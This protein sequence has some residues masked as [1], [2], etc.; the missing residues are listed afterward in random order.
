MANNKSL[1]MT[2]QIS[3]Q[4]KV[5]KLV[6]LI[7]VVV[8][9]AVTA[10]AY[11]DKAS[12][13]QSAILR[14]QPQIAELVRGVDVYEK[15]TYPNTP[16]VG[17]LLYPITALP[18]MATAIVFFLLKVVLVFI[19][20]YWAVNM[21]RG[22]STIP[23]WAIGLIALLVAR[24]MLSDLQHANINIIIMFIVMGGL[25][26]FTRGRTVPGGALIGL[27]T[28]MKV[29]PGLFLL[30][31]AWKRQWR[32]LA[33]CAIG[34]ALAVMLPALVLG[35]KTNFNMH[36]AWFN[37][38]IVPYVAEAE[39]EYTHHIN[40]SL[41]GVF[42][43]LFTDS[44]GVD[45][46]DELG[47]RQTNILAFDK[48]LASWIVRALLLTVL[49]MLLWIT[50]RRYTTHHDARWPAEFSLVLLAMLMLSERTWK[51]H[52]VVVLLP[53]TVVVIHMIRAQPGSGWR[54]YLLGTLIVFFVL[55]ACM[56][57]ELVGWMYKGVAHKFVEA[58]GSFFWAGVALFIAN[59]MIV[60]RCASFISA[61]DTAPATQAN[62][63]PR[64]S[65]PE[66]NIPGSTT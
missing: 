30:Y 48:D 43:G 54:K 56:S 23:W 38:M 33:G 24:P 39:T 35:P 9:V 63:A 50:R 47:F 10:A 20:G 49:A 31:F 41:P 55:T 46:G 22:R 13:G 1:N 59:A 7:G 61:D 17:I 21:V 16:I 6:V 58:F 4:E 8:I 11:I 26:L 36:V 34:G 57:G 65:A 14:W 66:R 28:V 64:T 40:Q 60:R 53:I 29:T 45:L 32:A 19:A 51:H 52:F 27:A 3:Q 44:P 18:A 5:W 15:Y 37:N 42:Y 12:E 2:S 62:D 25:F